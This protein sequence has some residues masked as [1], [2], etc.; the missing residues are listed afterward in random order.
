MTACSLLSTAGGGM[1]SSPSASFLSSNLISELCSW[2]CVICDCHHHWNHCQ[3]HSP[4]KRCWDRAMLAHIDRVVLVS[5]DC[6]VSR[7]RTMVVDLLVLSLLMFF[8]HPTYLTSSF[9]SSFLMFGQQSFLIRYGPQ[10]FG[11]RLCWIIIQ[12]RYRKRIIRLIIRAH[13]S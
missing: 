3:S 10:G 4:K 7:F 2:L 9:V 5:Q 6:S 13:C 8:F 1:F 11:N 12:N